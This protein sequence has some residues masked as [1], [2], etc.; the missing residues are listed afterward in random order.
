MRPQFVSAAIA[1][2]A[3]VACS[4]PPEQSALIR[5]TEL[6]AWP[7]GDFGTTLHLAMTFT[8]RSGGIIDDVEFDAHAYDAAGER[9][10][11]GLSR[12]I[13]NL[14]TGGPIGPGEQASHAW[15][16]DF[17]NPTVAC[18]VLTRV[19]VVRRSG[20]VQRYATPE[21]LASIM[22]VPNVCPR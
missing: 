16:L 4:G 15:S 6:E 10:H 18:F 20:L 8:N 21:A 14:S 12:P 13:E 9:V 19:T 2:L 11:D 5:I 1:I 3:L 17:D 22:A 7:P